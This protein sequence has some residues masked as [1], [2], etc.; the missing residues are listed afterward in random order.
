MIDDD[1]RCL[2]HSGVRV[3]AFGLGG[4]PLGGLFEAVDEDD[5]AEVVL[6][7]LRAGI[8]YI[9]TAPYYGFGESERRL[10]RIL[11]AIDRSSF[12]IS[13]KVGRLL[14]S[15]PGAD[16]DMFG[17]HQIQRIGDVAHIRLEAGARLRI[18]GIERLHARRHLA[19]CRRR[20]SR[21]HVG[22]IFQLSV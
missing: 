11:G 1:H 9:D 13:T 18:F 20:F 21:R 10:G 6:A 8:G 16:A 19:Y 3:S 5:A 7:A 2:G 12:V 15:R 4:A 14:E 22:E 17:S